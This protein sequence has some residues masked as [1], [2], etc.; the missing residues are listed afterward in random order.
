MRF[1]KNKEIKER[2][3]NVEIRTSDLS[4]WRLTQPAT[5]TINKMQD[6]INT[7]YKILTDAGL[8]EVVPKVSGG[9]RI[10]G[11]QFKLKENE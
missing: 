5:Y 3:S 4:V 1:F 8:I 6:E 2:L 11:V 9:Y 10:Q 7:L